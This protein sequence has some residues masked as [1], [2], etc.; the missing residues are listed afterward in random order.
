MLKLQGGKPEICVLWLLATMSCVIW[1]ALQIS[2]TECCVLQCCYFCSY[3]WYSHHY[4]LF[5]SPTPIACQV[6]LVKESLDAHERLRVR[7]EM[8]ENLTEKHCWTSQT[9]TVQDKLCADNVGGGGEQ[10]GTK[11]ETVTFNQCW[12]SQKCIQLVSQ[13][14]SSLYV[15][16]IWERDE[17]NILN[18]E[19]GLFCLMYLGLN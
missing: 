2:T 5:V 15:D 3:V 9:D 19:F 12:A 14:K 13:L 11:R 10:W 17:R 16:S 7:E 4:F 8:E 6:T 1:F 18:L